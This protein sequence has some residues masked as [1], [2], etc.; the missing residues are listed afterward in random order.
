MKNEDVEDRVA[1][2]RDKKNMKISLNFAYIQIQGIFVDPISYWREFFFFYLQKLDEFLLSKNKKFA[3][4]CSHFSS[5]TQNSF[6]LT[7]FSEIFF[8]TKLD[9]GKKFER[10]R[11]T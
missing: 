11:E 5:I 10:I 4:L 8:F 9:I 3:K 7:D 6:I 1:W 2:A